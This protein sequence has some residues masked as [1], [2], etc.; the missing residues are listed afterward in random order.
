MRIA[1][2]HD[3]A[4]ANAAE[5]VQDTVRQACYV[6][7]VLSDMG[8]DAILLP[9]PTGR[10]VGPMAGALSD[11]LAAHPV[12]LAVNLVESVNGGCRDAYQAVEVFKSL[13]LP[14]TG[15]DGAALMRTT[16]K[17]LTKHFLARAGLPC[18]AA[19]P[20]SGAGER[21]RGTFILK[22]VWEHASLG[23]DASSVLSDPLP[24]E[25]FAALAGRRV[26]FGGQWFAET[27]VEGRECN[28]SL[29]EDRKGVTVLP[30]SEIL[31]MNWPRERPRIVDYA[32]KWHEGEHVFEN[33]PRSFRFSEADGALLQELSR[34]AVRCW[35]VFGLSG[36]ARVDFRVDGNGR[37][38]IIDVNANPCLTPD[39]GFA[40]AVRH[41]GLTPQQALERICAGAM[42]RC[43]FHARAGR[44][45]S[46]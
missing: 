43:S 23:M 12:E 45:V 1:V 30:P 44:H 29:L 24:G 4:D 2:V 21:L 20:L 26:R 32:A 33:T 39:A 40:A 18:P 38:W 42:R 41:A 8:H 13:S 25:L 11:A 16:N 15:A 35:Y 34:Q 36:Y 3:L 7:D 27:Y 22:S 46:H 6:R 10:G 31:F 19:A 37:P 5:D 9:V 28:I 14:F 17:L